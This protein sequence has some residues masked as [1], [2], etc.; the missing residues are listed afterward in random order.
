MH[1]NKTLY[2]KNQFNEGDLEDGYESPTG[3]GNVNG[4]NNKENNS[5]WSS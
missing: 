2:P 5:N 3:T 1:Q 4:M